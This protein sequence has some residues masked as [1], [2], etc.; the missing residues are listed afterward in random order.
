MEMIL[1]I[2]FPSF[3]G[4]G[5]IKNYV[6]HLIRGRK[7]IG[8]TQNTLKFYENWA[9]YYGAD[10]TSFFDWFLF[11]RR[12]EREKTDK[13]YG[14]QARCQKEYFNLRLISTKGILDLDLKWFILCESH[15]HL[16][17]YWKDSGPLKNMVVLV[18]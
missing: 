9:L 8:V 2:C 1:S 14:V 10:K 15:P 7:S 13:G 16:S 17:E 3:E 6:T 11:Q 5:V 4:N 12:K 18:V